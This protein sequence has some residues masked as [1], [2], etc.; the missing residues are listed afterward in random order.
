MRRIIHWIL[1]YVPGVIRMFKVELLDEIIALS[2]VAEPEQRERL[3]LS[4]CVI[5]E[6]LRWYHNGMWLRETLAVDWHL[7]HRVPAPVDIVDR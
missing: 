7:I 1:V 3:L 5:D 4:A 2:R 6:R